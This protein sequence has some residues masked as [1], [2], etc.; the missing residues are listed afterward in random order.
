M[1]YV[2]RNQVWVDAGFVAA[3]A[4]PAKAE[5]LLESPRHAPAVSQHKFDG[6]APPLSSG[7]LLRTNTPRFTETSRWP[8][9]LTSIRRIG[10]QSRDPTL[11]TETAC[12]PARVESACQTTISMLSVTNLAEQSHNRGYDTA[13]V[14]APR[15][16]LKLAVSLVP[17]QFNRSP[18]EI[19]VSQPNVVSGFKELGPVYA[20]NHEAPCAAH[21][22]R[23]ARLRK[24]PRTK[25]SS[26]GRNCEGQMKTLW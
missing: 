16:G 12:L 22:R 14:R 2:R 6:P 4:S 15:G 3:G 25:Q 24:Y 11:R 8:L 26:G 21:N 17:T 13:R 20:K 23:Q 18:V 10:R 7:A 9:S 1:D 19:D 5:R